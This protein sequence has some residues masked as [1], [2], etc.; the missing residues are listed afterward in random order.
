MRLPW[1]T[2]QTGLHHAKPNGHSNFVFNGIYIM[3]ILI[4]V[5]FLWLV[6]VSIFKKKKKTL[7]ALNILE[8]WQCFRSHSGVRHKLQSSV[9]QSH[10]AVRKLPGFADVGLFA[11]RGNPRI[12]DFKKS[13]PYPKITR[14]GLYKPSKYGWVYDCFTNITW[15]IYR[16]L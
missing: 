14:N 10:V 13:K 1:G 7:P 12:L 2:G 16:D 9:G 5:E 11:Q 6:S 4:I 3:Y 8:Q 15:G